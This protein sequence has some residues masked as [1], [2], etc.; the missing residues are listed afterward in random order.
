M[1]FLIKFYI[2]KYIDYTWLKSKTRLSCLICIVAFDDPLTYTIPTDSFLPQETV[3]DFQQINKPTFQND[4]VL[5]KCTE[6][7]AILFIATAKYGY[8]LYY[9]LSSTRQM[10]LFISFTSVT[11]CDV[12]FSP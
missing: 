12:Q 6:S 3:G 4:D 2:K 8:G 10:K 5:H 1:Y 11:S 9:N 7:M